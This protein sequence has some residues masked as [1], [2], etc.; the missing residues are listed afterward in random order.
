MDGKILVLSRLLT[1]SLLFVLS[2]NAYSDREYSPGDV[3]FISLEHSESLVDFYYKGNLV[4]KVLKDNK[5]YLLFGIPYYTKNGANQFIFKGKRIIKKM[6][7][8]ISKKKYPIQRIEIKK[9]KVKTENEYKRIAKERSQIIQAKKEMYDNFPDYMFI[10]PA[11]GPTSGTYGTV[12]YYNGKK[13]N[14]HNGHDIAA[15]LGTPIYS[16]SSGIVII[17][18]NYYYNGKF[19]MINHGNNLISM[20]LHLN[21]IAVKK[22][23]V[24]N[25]GQFIG[26][27]GTTGLSTG[28]HLHW[29]VLLNNSYIDP[30]KLINN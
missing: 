14:Y 28:P 3:V 24:I 10:I 20:F 29:S 1:I 26:T 11:Q 23:D 7:F 25:K 4:T 13:G 8:N 6:T 21:D 27:I 19:I 16:P 30:L 17:T 2:G 12:R 9:F 18:G 15:A 5:H 22:D